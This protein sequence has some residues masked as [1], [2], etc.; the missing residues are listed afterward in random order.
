MVKD[1]AKLELDG[2]VIDS[3][4]FDS[5]R[6]RPEWIDIEIT[7]NRSWKMRMHNIKLLPWDK[8]KIE[9][10]QYDPSKGCISFR[11][12]APGQTGRNPIGGRSGKNP[13]A[14]QSR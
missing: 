6:V 14:G 9:I 13:S 3:L 11:Y 4:G 5:Y 8:V 7:A 1:D 12:P 10:N 2:E